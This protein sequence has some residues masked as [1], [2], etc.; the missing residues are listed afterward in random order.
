MQLFVNNLWKANLNKSKVHQV[1]GNKH[2]ARWH[3][4]PPHGPTLLMWSNTQPTERKLI[5]RYTRD[6]WKPGKLGKVLFDFL[7][8]KTLY[9]HLGDD[10]SSVE[11]KCRSF[12]RILLSFLHG[13]LFVLQTAN[14]TS[15]SNTVKYPQTTDIFPRV[16]RLCSFMQHWGEGSMCHTAGRRRGGDI[17]LAGEGGFWM[18]TESG[19]KLAH[20]DHRPVDWCNFK[21]TLRSN[22]KLSFLK[23][24]FMF[25]NKWEKSSCNLQFPSTTGKNHR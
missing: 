3:W 22:R 10:S 11:L 17:L 19:W 25:L 18:E 6:H 5:T 14:F 4:F 16:W 15:S 2:F 23:Q 21:K 1:Q 20:S 7:L 13:G 24:V 12:Q 9:I 8:I